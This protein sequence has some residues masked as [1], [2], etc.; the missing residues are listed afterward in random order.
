MQEAIVSCLLACLP[1]VLACLL[2][3]G[4][5]GPGLLACCLLACWLACRAVLAY[6]VLYLHAEEGEMP[7]LLAAS[8]ARQ[9]LE[10]YAWR[11]G[12]GAKTPLPCES[13]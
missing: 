6:V 7:P 2:A 12:W 10:Y 3:G 11:S 4:A 9:L 8:R 13:P 5:P 1:A